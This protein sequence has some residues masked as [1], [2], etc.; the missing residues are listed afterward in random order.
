MSAL[1]ERQARGDTYSA[2]KVHVLV[3][4]IES[5]PVLHRAISFLFLF[6]RAEM[7]DIAQGIQSCS[8]TTALIL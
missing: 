4:T 6:A 5:D 1:A 2:R 7:H 3:H 8:I